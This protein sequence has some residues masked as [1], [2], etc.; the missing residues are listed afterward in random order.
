MPQH[1]QQ[2]EELPIGA[3][4]AQSY[5][6]PKSLSASLTTPGLP[7]TTSA[8]RP[9]ATSAARPYSEKTSFATAMEES[10]RKMTDSSVHTLKI[11]P[12]EEPMSAGAYLGGGAAIVGGATLG[13]GATIAG[14]LGCTLSEIPDKDCPDK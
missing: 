7:L 13:C 2:R 8:A 11:H 1:E 10:D 4:H 9:L 14:V 12:T 3:Q 6:F 5:Q